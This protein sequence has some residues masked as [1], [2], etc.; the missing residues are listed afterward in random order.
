[1]CYFIDLMVLQRNWTNECNS[2][3]FFWFTQLEIPHGIA[4]YDYNGTNTGELSF[5]VTLKSIHSH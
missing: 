5:Q 2:A 1:M 3:L 4:E